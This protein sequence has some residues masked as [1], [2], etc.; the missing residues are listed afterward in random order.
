MCLTAAASRGSRPFFGTCWTR[1][2]ECTEKKKNV[3]GM[4]GHVKASMCKVFLYPTSQFPN[5]DTDY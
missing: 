3:I 2:T 1:I 5:N 4:V